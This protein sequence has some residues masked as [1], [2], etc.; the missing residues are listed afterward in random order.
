MLMEK[1]VAFDSS[2]GS[3]RVY[4]PRC[5]VLLDA[6]RALPVRRF[7]KDWDDPHWIAG[8]DEATS[9]ALAQLAFDN[10]FVVD[11]AAAEMMASAI[12]AEPVMN[13]TCLKTA[14]IISRFEVRTSYNPEVV[15]LLKSCIGARMDATKT[16]SLPPHDTAIQV[17]VDLVIRFGLTVSVETLAAT[18]ALIKTVGAE[19]YVE[20]CV[21]IDGVIAQVEARSSTAKKAL[22]PLAVLPTNFVAAWASDSVTRRKKAKDQALA[23]RTGERALQR[24]EERGFEEEAAA[25]TSIQ[26]Q[27]VHQNLRTLA[28]VCDGATSVDDVGFNGPDSKVGRGLALLPKLE[29]LQAALARSMLAKYTRQLG[30]VAIEAMY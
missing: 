2:I 24:A 21:L 20:R 17:V 29:P 28:G 18:Q 9:A 3:Y 25:I 19:Q 16:W 27:A 15:A 26:I 10:S 7:H 5:S 1:V 23:Q 30:K 12:A 4:F 6:V 14:G 11:A 13:I 22:P 8:A